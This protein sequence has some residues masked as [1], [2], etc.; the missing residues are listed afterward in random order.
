M[1]LDGGEVNMEERG[2]VGGM[3][4]VEGGETVI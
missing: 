3:E 2:K 1:G 4:V